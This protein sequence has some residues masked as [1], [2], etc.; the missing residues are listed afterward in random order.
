MILR[1]VLSHFAKKKKPAQTKAKSAPK[2][3]KQALNLPEEFVEEHLMKLKDT[4]KSAPDVNVRGVTA[5]INRFFPPILER[6]LVELQSE[7]YHLTY[8]KMY[9]IQ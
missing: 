4:I 9:S 1:Q 5:H 3:T 6:P 2:K 7:N 8:P